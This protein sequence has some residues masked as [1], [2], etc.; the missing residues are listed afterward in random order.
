M[1][2][3]LRSVASIAGITVGLKS[4]GL[5]SSTKDERPKIMIWQRQLL[6][7]ENSLEQLRNAI[8]AGYVLVSEFDDDPEHWPAIGVNKNLNFTGMHAVQTSTVA[9]A[10][11]L[12]KINP[13]VAVFENCL[14]K[15]PNIDPEKW[16][17]VG[18]RKRIK[19]FFGALNRQNS[20]KEWIEPLNKVL[21]QQP[22]SWE[23]EVVHDKDFFNAVRSE[24]KNFT[25]TCNYAKYME[26]LKSCHV[27][28]LPLERTDFN[29]MK[30]DLKFVESAGTKVL[31]IASPTVP[32]I[33]SAIKRQ[34]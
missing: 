24:N 9:L 6:T 25:P 31:T 34:E 28:L 23:V 10:E 11:K 17:D 2:Q 15:L 18:K 3:P 12:K 27:S 33:L 19:L 8:R 21:L 5:S 4:D 13:N 30:S 7:Y 20:W 1:I 32:K 22:N 26:I 14:E 29:K 16:K